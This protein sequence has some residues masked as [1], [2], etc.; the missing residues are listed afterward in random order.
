MTIYSDLWY[1]LIATPRYDKKVAD[2]LRRAHNHLLQRKVKS[3]DAGRFGTEV[4]ELREGRAV[5]LRTTRE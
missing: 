5:G 2:R 3:A 1:K 4:S